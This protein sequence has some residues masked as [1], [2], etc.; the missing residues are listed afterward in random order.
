MTERRLDTYLDLCTQVYDLSKPNPPADAY[1]FYRAYVSEAAGP[2]LE[3]MCGTGR[4]LLPLVHERFDVHGFDAS[5]HM[6]DLLREKANTRRI[7]PVVWQ[8]FIEELDRTER[9]RLAIIPSGSFGLII[10]PV[11]AKEVLV[12][13]R[14]HLSDDGLL[15]FEA[16]NPQ[17]ESTPTGI[18]RGSVWPRSEGK[19]I[20]ANYLEQPLQENVSTTIW[21]YELVEGGRIIQTEMETI[22]VRSYPPDQMIALLRDVGFREVFQVKAFEIGQ[23]PAEGDEQI[24]YECRK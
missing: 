3:P 17:V 16:E 24:I 12:K 5:A 19:V 20:I 6:L 13:L 10:D 1:A 7:K 18:W 14:D 9:Y 8:G 22:R 21:R 23:R 4:F 11:K 2:V 15:V